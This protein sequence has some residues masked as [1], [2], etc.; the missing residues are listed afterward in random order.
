VSHEKRLLAA[1]KRSLASRTDLSM[2][3]FD[4]KMREFPIK[5]IK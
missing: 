2:A 4:G 3:R 1:F 5:G